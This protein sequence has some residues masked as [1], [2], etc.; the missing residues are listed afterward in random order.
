[1][2]DKLIKKEV[3]HQ[4]KGNTDYA[5]GTKVSIGHDVFQ[6]IRKDVPSIQESKETL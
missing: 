5:D 1:M 3:L 6:V 2:D 4:G